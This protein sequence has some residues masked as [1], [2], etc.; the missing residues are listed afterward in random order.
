LQAQ[1]LIA[2]GG[3]IGASAGEHLIEDQPQGIKIALH[4]DATAGELLRSLV[5]RRALPRVERAPGRS[6]GSEAKIG[7][8][9][10]STAVDH[11]VGGLEIAVQYALFMRRL[12]AG[13]QFGGDFEGLIGRHSPDPPQQRRQVLA[14]HEFHAKERNAVCFSDVMDPADVRMGNPA[15]E[16]G[17]VVESVQRGCIGRQVPGQ[18]FE[19]NLLPQDQVEGPV[20]LPHASGAGQRFNPVTSV[21]HHARFDPESVLTDHGRIFGQSARFRFR[22]RRSSQPTGGT[23]FHVLGKSG[24][25]AGAGP[26]RVTNCII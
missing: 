5:G 14:V 23:R 20:H 7:D 4:R 26:H 24:K 17:L 3:L 18:E 11:D 2:A 21:Q 8:Q 6:R 12:E 13:A 22:S 16:A 25:A 15:R 10:L 9:D 1:H 19:G